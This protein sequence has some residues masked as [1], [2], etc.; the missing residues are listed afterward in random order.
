MIETKSIDEIINEYYDVAKK[1]FEL[2]NIK[3][4]KVGVIGFLLYV[5]GHI[6]KDSHYYY[7]YLFKELSVLTA[8]SY[9]SLLLHAS[10]Y[11]FTPSFARPATLKGKLKIVVPKWNSSLKERE[12]IIPKGTKFYVLD[13]PWTLDAHLKIIQQGNYAY[14]VYTSDNEIKNVQAYVYDN[15]KDINTKIIEFDLLYT[16]QYEE[17]KITFTMP[18]YEFGTFYKYILELENDKFL[19]DIDV[20]IKLNLHKYFEKFDISFVKFGYS[21]EDK[22]VFISQLDKNK[23]ALEFGNGINGLYI[24]QNSEVEIIYKETLGEK[25]NIFNGQIAINE[26]ITKIE[27]YIDGKIENSLIDSSLIFGEITDAITDGKSIKSAESLKKDILNFIKTRNTLVKLSDYQAIFSSLF[28]CKFILKK[29]N[30]LDNDIYIYGVLTDSFLN[31]PLYTTSLTLNENFFKGK[32]IIYKPEYV[33]KKKNKIKLPFEKEVYL[34]KDVFDS[35]EVY[36]NDTSFI[37]ENS[38]ISFENDENIYKVV[39]VDKDENKITLDKKV[40]LKRGAKVFKVEEDKI[41]LVSPFLYIKDDVLNMYKGYIVEEKEHYMQIKGIFSKTNKVSNFK[42][43]IKLSKDASKVDIKLIE[44]DDL[45]SFNFVLNIPALGI[46]EKELNIF[47]NFSVSIDIDNIFTFLNEFDIYLEAYD[48]NYEKIAL[49]MLE[50]FKLIYDISDVFTIKK[51]TKDNQTY[52]VQIPFI[53]KEQYEENKSKILEKLKNLL[54]Y[55]NVHKNRLL[56]VSHNFRFFNTID[57]K[58]TSILKEFEKEQDF[59]NFPLKLKLFLYI[60]KSYLVKND[61]NLDDILYQL[62]LDLA[63]FL[64]ENFTTS[65]IK[66]Y[67][68][69]V[70][71][72]V[73]NYPFVK[74]VK[75]VTPDTNIVIKD[76]YEFLK[77]KADNKQYIVSFVPSYFWWDINDIE[78]DYKL[79]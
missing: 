31:L 42:I 50:K 55:S 79:V 41:N 66:F 33:Y 69:K 75:V 70:I 1:Y 61:A 7:N 49:F 20:Y 13:I 60:D 17:R 74:Y 62:K 25:G 76:T 9:S 35:N 53:S 64:L 73:H 63:K 4:S 12:I 46:K 51:Y 36:V 15:E 8:T 34:V 45:S 44:I 23:Y 77:E 67:K 71:D 52:L 29:V 48:E 78:I 30:L 40:F 10:L 5:L 38:Y 57:L 47:N 24:P 68:S 26:K 59:L 28:D 32:D 14:A 54:Y 3:I 27:Y 6:K 21:G 72:F 43:S 16:K 58:D 37:L 22:V 18:F 56:T 19:A 39:Y 11:G 2:N 65:D